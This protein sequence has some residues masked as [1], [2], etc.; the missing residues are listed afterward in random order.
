VVIMSQAAWSN[1][2]FAK[3]EKVTQRQAPFAFVCGFS[4]LRIKKYVDA[5]RIESRG[6]VQKAHNSAL[7]A[8]SRQLTA[9]HTAQRFPDRGPFTAPLLTWS[10][11]ASR[12]MAVDRD[13]GHG[14]RE[15]IDR[16]PLAQGAP[17]TTPALPRHPC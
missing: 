4:F 6:V 9:G 3:M 8:H 2:S 13:T 15:M 5:H 7:P 1:R 11:M 17:V 10:A 16:P 12:S 14:I